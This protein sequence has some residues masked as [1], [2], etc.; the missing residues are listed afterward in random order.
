MRITKLVGI[1]ISLV[2]AIVLMAGVSFA[3]EEK[4]AVRGF[5]DNLPDIRTGVA[6]DMTES[7]GNDILSITTVDV[8]RWGKNQFGM[9]EDKLCLG[10]G[11]TTQLSNDENIN[12]ALSISWHIGGLEQ[13][14]FSYP[15]AKL[16]DIE[17]GG[18][19]SRDLDSQDYQAGLQTTILRF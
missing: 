15:L 19:I 16:V 14:G 7:S 1:S 4:S 12:P 9:T 18:F 8:I 13:W 11:L 5:L 3:Q 2:V 6:W 17:V 10:A